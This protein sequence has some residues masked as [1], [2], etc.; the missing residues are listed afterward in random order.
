MSNYELLGVSYDADERTIK[1]AYATLIKQ[2]RPDSHPQEFARIRSAYESL[3][4][5]CRYQQHYEE[6]ESSS[7]VL[8]T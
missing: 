6:G 3:L 1:R 2:Y 7:D 4:E 5:Q 8:K